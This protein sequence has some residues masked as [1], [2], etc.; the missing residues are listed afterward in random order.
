[1]A[2]VTFLTG[3]VWGLAGAIAMVILMQ[4]LGSDDPPPFAVFWAQYLGDG[5]PE[6]AMPQALI[7]HA[8]YAVVAGIVYVLIFSAFDLGFS[9]TTYTG[10]IIWGIVWAVILFIGAAVFWINLV[11]DLD[12]DQDQVMTMAVAHLGYGLTLGILSAAVP[13]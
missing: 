7:L 4:L 9:I 6:S 1:M 5:D 8:I 11:L 12:P 13:L 2:T 10:G 3:A